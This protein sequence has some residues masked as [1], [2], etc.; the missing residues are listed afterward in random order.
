M[1]I[2]VSAANSNSL[3]FLSKSSDSLSFLVLLDYEATGRN[4]VHET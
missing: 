2:L 4:P 3:L 1:Q